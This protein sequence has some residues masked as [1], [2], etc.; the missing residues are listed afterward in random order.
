MKITAKRL[1]DLKKDCDKLWAEIIKKRAGY[2]SE[3]SGKPGKQ[4]GGDNVLNAHHIFGKPNFRLRYELDNGICVTN[5]EHN[6][7]IH[8]AGNAEEYREKIIRKIGIERWS[9]LAELK[10]DNGK[11]SIQLT[12]LYL[13]KE[14][15]KL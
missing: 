10:R 2:K 1:K 14:L 11:T 5:G 3:L 15:E 13:E 4:A 7:G 9:R 8:N 12:K 6:F